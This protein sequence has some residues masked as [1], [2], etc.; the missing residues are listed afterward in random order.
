MNSLQAL[1]QAR[2]GKS[3]VCVCVCVRA[4]VRACM[5]AALKHPSY[6][7]TKLIPYK[8][9]ASCERVFLN[10]MVSKCQLNVLLEGKRTIK[11]QLYSEPF[12]L[13][14]AASFIS[15]H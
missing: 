11:R 3:C 15:Q 7:L 9:V 8:G 2:M 10:E 4:C 12:T 13:R 6:V 5:H 1:G 14:E